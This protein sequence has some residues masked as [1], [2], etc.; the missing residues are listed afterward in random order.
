MSVSVLI[1]SFPVSWYS[2]CHFKVY[3]PC[4]YYNC[5]TVRPFNKKKSVIE[6]RQ[7]QTRVELLNQHFFADNLGMRLLHG[8]TR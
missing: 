4:L 7:K 6:Q 3:I 2:S 8:K 1:Q 5:S